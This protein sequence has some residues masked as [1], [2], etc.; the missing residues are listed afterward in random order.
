MLAAIRRITNTLA[1]LA[2]LI[3]PARYGPLAAA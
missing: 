2:P 1:I 3:V